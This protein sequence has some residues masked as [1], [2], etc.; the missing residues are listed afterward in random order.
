MSGSRMLRRLGLDVEA[1]REE[2]QHID[3][4]IDGADRI[5]L[6]DCS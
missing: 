4:G 2:V 5:V 6:V 1:E 3:E